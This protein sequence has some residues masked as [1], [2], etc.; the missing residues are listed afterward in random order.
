M[1]VHSAPAVS[2]I[3]VGMRIGKTKIFIAN[4]AFKILEDLRIAKIEET[5]SSFRTVE[6][7]VPANQDEEG[8]LPCGLDVPAVSPVIEN[9]GIGDTTKNMFTEL[10]EKVK[11]AETVEGSQKKLR[12]DEVASYESSAEGQ[13]LSQSM[14]DLPDELPDMGMSEVVD[15]NTISDLSH[16]SPKKSEVGGKFDENELLAIIRERDLLKLEVDQMRRH[17]TGDDDKT[18]YFAFTDQEEHELEVLIAKIKEEAN[19]LQVERNEVRTLCSSSDGSVWLTNEIQNISR[20]VEDMIQE[21]QSQIQKM[22]DDQQRAIGGETMSATTSG[23]DSAANSSALTS[24][25]MKL[26]QQV[27]RLSVK[28]GGVQYKDDAKF[29]TSSSVDFNKDALVSC[30]RSESSSNGKTAELEYLH[31]EVEK[32]KRRAATAELQAQKEQAEATALREVFAP[33]MESSSENNTDK[34]DFA[35]AV[36]AYKKKLALRVAEPS[37]ASSIEGAYDF[38]PIV[39]EDMAYFANFDDGNSTV[40]SVTVVSLIDRLEAIINE[41]GFRSHDRN[42]DELRNT[43]RIREVNY[44]V[45]EMQREIDK[46]RERLGRSLATIDELEK[47]ITV[48]SDSSAPTATNVCTVENNNSQGFCSFFNFLRRAAPARGGID[49][50]GHSYV[51]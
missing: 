1:H 9:S 24:Q 37:K 51:S 39:T 4:D 49:T 17:I 38:D 45:E 11:T 42:D 10:D 13:V 40:S 41:G 27:S 12:F 32:M 46:A 25:M 18:H 19:N 22:M 16:S 43:F 6:E 3:D 50:S 29:S 34:V 47:P 36:E 30:P 15:Q 35:A 21:Q 28:V 20:T 48:A 23:E 8:S 26:S 2:L 14:Y 5:M 44:E 7:S 31:L 33:L